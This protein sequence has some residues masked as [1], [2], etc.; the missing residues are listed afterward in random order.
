M[1]EPA[2][3]SDLPLLMEIEKQS[4]M[5]DQFSE[6]LYLSF[7]LQPDT[8]VYLC[9]EAEKARGSLVLKFAENDNI[10]QIISVAVPPE[11]QGL[12]YGK[13]MMQFAESHAIRRQRYQIQL[14]VRSSNLKAIELYQSLHY[15]EG[16]TLRDFYGPGIDGIRFVKNLE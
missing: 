12:G 16:K 14:E 7:I 5:Q 9:R 4:F 15:E 10:C 8:E 6:A 1:I 3:E 11:F 2:S 13:E